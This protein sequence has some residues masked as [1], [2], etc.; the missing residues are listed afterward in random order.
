VES[1]KTGTSGQGKWGQKMPFFPERSLWMI[2]YAYLEGVRVR[3][4]WEWK[5]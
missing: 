1:A 5:E 2:S 4:E 3:S